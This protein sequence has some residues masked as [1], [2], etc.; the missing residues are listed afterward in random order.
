VSRRLSR[1]EL[2]LIVWKRADYGRLG[3]ALLLCYLRYPGQVLEARE[4]PPAALVSFIA[5]QLGVNLTAFAEYGRR[6]QMSIS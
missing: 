1:E 6:D 2:E 3:Y 4:V 5:Q